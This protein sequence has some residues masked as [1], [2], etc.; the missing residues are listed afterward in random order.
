MASPTKKS[1]RRSPQTR[2]IIPNRVFLA[3]PWRNIRPKYERWVEKTR[4]KIALSF[5]IVGGEDTQDAEDLLEVIKDRLSRSSYAIFDATGGNAN[6]SLEYGYAEA[7][8]IPRALYLSTHATARKTKDTPIIADLAGRRTNKYTRERSLHHLLTEFT[9]KHSYTQRFD[10]FLRKA[11]P[12]ARAG[13]RAR[14]RTLAIKVVRCLDHS[15]ETSCVDVVNRLLNDDAKY[16][17]G[18]IDLILRK[19]NQ[20][21][22]WFAPKGRHSKIRLL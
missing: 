21:R 1:A 2:K 15:P 5:I 10:Q 17:S 9:K 14:L 11:F 16:Q 6:V 12:K 3:I 4:P 7:Q 22:V 20:Y 19:G 18:E 13:Q 8:K